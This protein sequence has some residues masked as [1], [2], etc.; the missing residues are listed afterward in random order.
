MMLNYYI[1]Y[2]EYSDDLSRDSVC[3]YEDITCMVCG[4]K[5]AVHQGKYCGGYCEYLEF[6][7]LQNIYKQKKS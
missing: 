6:K 3:Y 5:P 7:K 2:D 1:E 4:K